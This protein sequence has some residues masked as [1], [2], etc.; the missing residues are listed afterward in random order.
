MCAHA[1]VCVCPR[2]R[3][4]MCDCVS[5]IARVIHSVET[6]KFDSFNWCPWIFRCTTYPFN[7]VTRDISG[8]LIRG[9]KELNFLLAVHFRCTRHFMI[10][11][12]YNFCCKD[13]VLFT[14]FLC[15]GER[16]YFLQS[17]VLISAVVGSFVW[18]YPH[19]GER[20]RWS[21]RIKTKIQPISN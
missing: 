11:F 20:L 21:F 19:D 16:L 10:I 2:A 7:D 3:V 6:N 17:C 14:F 15:L 4:C 18:S 9:Q 8:A 13:F 5:V 1:S 12:D